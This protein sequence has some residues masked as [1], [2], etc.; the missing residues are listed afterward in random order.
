MLRGGGQRRFPALSKDSEHEQGP[1]GSELWVCEHQ[2]DC[3]LQWK[4]AALLRNGGDAAGRHPTGH[5]GTRRLSF[6]KGPN[7]DRSFSLLS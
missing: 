5:S 4:D 7:A 1:E 3:C 2:E 6:Y